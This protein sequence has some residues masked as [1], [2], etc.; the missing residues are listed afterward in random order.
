MDHAVHG[1]VLLDGAT[2]T[3]LDRRGVD[4]GLPLWSARAILEAPDV[5]KAIHCEYL[6]AGADAIV[7]NTFRTHERSLAKAGMGDRAEALTCQAVE[8]ARAARDEVKSDALVFGSVAPLEDCYRPDLAPDATACRAEH[9]QLIR[10]LVEAG[11]DLVLIE[12]MCSPHEALAAAEAAE[13]LCPGAWA[14]SLGRAMDDIVPQVEGAQFIGL[15]CVPATTLAEEITHLR[16]L[17]PAETPIAAYGN[18]GRVDDTR[19]WVNT[20]AVEPEQYAALAM[21]WIE[22]GASIVGGCCGTTPATI[23]AIRARLDRA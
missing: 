2:G 14:I 12:T 9:S 19:G 17:A 10:H 5:L 4:T 13:E 21:E 18:V 7:T 22:A 6:E 15:N 11:V 20:D 3:E 8:I 23:R 1:I 16:S